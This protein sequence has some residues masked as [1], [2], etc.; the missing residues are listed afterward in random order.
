M[1]TKVTRS[2]QQMQEEIL[3]AELFV[4]RVL[5]I[6]VLIS[7]AVILIGIISFLI[8]GNSGYPGTT[9]PTTLPGIIHGIAAG[10]PFAIIL[11]G[12]FLLILTPIM[13]VGV[14]I[15]IFV[16]A[17]DTLYIGISCLVFIIL[18]V[19]LLLGKAG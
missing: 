18:I 4:S 12:L 3:T 17:K 9:F 14:T 11:G 6:G 16:K 5:R 10:K 7:G 13:R 19:S 15:L 1:S 8:S 2:E